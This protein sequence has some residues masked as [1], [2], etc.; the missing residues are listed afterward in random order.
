MNFSKKANGNYME[1]CG[2]ESFVKERS[3]GELSIFTQ[4][5]ILPSYLTLF[6]LLSNIC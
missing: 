6:T 3:V 5:P 4:H 2:S 1:V